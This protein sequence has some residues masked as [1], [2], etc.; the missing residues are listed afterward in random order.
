MVGAR[1]AE[2]RSKLEEEAKGRQRAAG[3]DRKSDRGK[4]LRATLPEPIPDTERP[5]DVI[6]KLVGV[7]GRT[8]SA[9]VKVIEEGAPELAKA[10]DEGRMA[11]SRAAKLT[12]RA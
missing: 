12:E 9:A 8:I 4:S 1:A 3:G 2:M 7:S 6:G 11:V 5:R 10:V